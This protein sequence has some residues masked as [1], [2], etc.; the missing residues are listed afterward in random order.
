MLDE[1]KK[2]GGIKCAN[3]GVIHFEGGAVIY[4]PLCHAR[5]GVI[6]EK[7]VNS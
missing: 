3:C 6:K 7:G 4:C 1:M 2:Q 5:D